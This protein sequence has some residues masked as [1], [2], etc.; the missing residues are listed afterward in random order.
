M[1]RNVLFHHALELPNTAS[2]VQIV[3]LHGLFVSLFAGA[4]LLFRYSAR[5]A[6]PPRAGASG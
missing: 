6:F 1:N 4:A 2:H 5:N 3:I